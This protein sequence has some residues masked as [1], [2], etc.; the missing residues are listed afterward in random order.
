M[1]D[2]AGGAI[3]SKV[4][5]RLPPPLSPPLLFLRSGKLQHLEVSCTLETY[6]HA[7]A[8]KAA[9]ENLRGIPIG[10]LLCWRALS[11][12]SFRPSRTASRTRPRR[13]RRRQSLS[14]HRS[15]DRALCLAGRRST[16]PCA[17]PWEGGRARERTANVVLTSEAERTLCGVTVRRRGHRQ[18]WSAGWS[19]RLLA[20]R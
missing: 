14:D 7:R 5:L 20:W 13:R 10:R 4:T 6:R 8:R 16:L 19:A 9:A 1:A 15:G 11:G 17:M 2:A 3:R 12:P 18:A